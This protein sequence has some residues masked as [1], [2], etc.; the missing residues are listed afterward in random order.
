M[1]NSNRHIQYHCADQDITESLKSLLKPFDQTIKILM[2]GDVM[3]RGGRKILKRSLVKIKKS[4]DL[5]LVTING[6][7]LAGGFG[8][9]EKIYHE[10][11]DCGVDVITMGNHWKD[12]PDIHKLRSLYQN[13]VLPQNL[14][15]VSDVNQAPQFFLPAR[16][17][18]V[19]VVNLMGVF[20]MKEEYENP[21]QF[22]IREKQ[23]Y[24]DKVH[25]GAHIVIADIHAEASAEK[26]AIA[27]YYDG[28]FSALIGTHTHTPT[29]DE[30]LTKQ[31]TAFLTDVGMTGPYASVIGMN[32]ERVIRRLSSTTGEKI[33]YE[34]AEEDLWFCGFLIEVDPLTCLARSCTRLQCRGFEE[35]SWLISYAEK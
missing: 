16:N 2:V 31:G 10:M 34:V 28:I 29:S 7:N 5:D 15:G 26:Q 22:L 12:K 6:E 27:W 21:F 23:N 13:V 17:K 1:Q 25:S 8:I 30:R 11:I 20:A 32:A 9:T 33:A 4:L 18:S 3:G 19:S 35:G 24:Q 14:K